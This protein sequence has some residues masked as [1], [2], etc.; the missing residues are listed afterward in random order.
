MAIGI[1]LTDIASLQNE[2]TALT[3]L[4]D[5][6]DAIAAAL[7]DGLSRSGTTPNTM[8]SALDMNSNQILNLPAPI[9]T[10][11]P[12]RVADA[13]TLNGGGIITV[14]PLPTGGTTGQVLA[15]IDNGNYDVQWNSPQVVSTAGSSSLTLSGSTLGTVALSGDVTSNAN[16]FNTTIGN[17][18][19]TA[20]KF[21]ASS[22]LSLVGNPTNSS[23][24]VSDIIGNANQIPM[25]NSSGNSLAFTAV[26]GDVS[27]TNGTFTVAA[28]AVTGSKMATNTVANSNLAQ[29]AAFTIKG[30]PTS[31][32]A[33]EID[34]T[35][36]GLVPK[37]SPASLDEIMIYD[38]SGVAIKKTTIGA[39]GSVGSVASIAGN[40]GAFTLGAGLTNSTNVLL[41]DPVYK[42]GQLGGLT[43]SN[44]GVTPNTILD[45]AAGFAT[46]DDVSTEMSIASAYTKTTGSW[47]VGSGN[48]ALDTGSVAN[49]TWYH[50]YIIERTDTGVVD[51]LFSTSA[52]SP[53]MPTSYTKKRR[54]GSFKTDTSA[55][56]LAFS[57]NGDEFLWSAP[58]N[59]ISNVAV[60]TSNVTL[61][62]T[63]PLGIVVNALFRAAGSNGSGGAAFL[64]YSMAEGSQTVGS[65]NLNS[66]L[67]S[68]SAGNYAAN[69]FNIRTNTS[70]QVRVISGTASGGLYGS[71]YGWVDTRGKTV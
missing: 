2:T 34:F 20:A 14:S 58:P 33:N 17:N 46:S 56:I 61:T 43:L 25:V 18:A 24:N 38:V 42:R 66:N 23:A 49:S 35:I 21:R 8:G 71:T 15:K 52:S 39:V 3:A 62:L 31:A 1:S 36:D 9:G 28:G 22:G 41:A 30:N 26:T 68:P 63:V 54:V 69:T 64:F 11:S 37:V 53:T 51:F 13:T 44:D 10:N 16:S 7:P 59:D 65:N 19:V 67:I 29:A 32:T 50:V 60:G 12:L 70:Q 47:T 55:H 5:N 40:T 45:I 27:N 4:N 57:Q 6:F 48:G